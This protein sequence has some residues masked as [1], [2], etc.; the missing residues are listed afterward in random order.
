MDR[1]KRMGELPIR[2][3]YITKIFEVRK[4]DKKILI[5]GIAMRRIT[6]L[7]IDKQTEQKCVI[8]IIAI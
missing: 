4:N 5:F 6:L 8:T 2:L 3:F 1:D 7:K